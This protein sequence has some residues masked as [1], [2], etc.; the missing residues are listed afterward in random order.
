MAGPVIMK[1]GSKELKENFLPRIAAGEIEF[2]LGY[3]EPD[4]G[5]DLSRIEM[6]AVEDGDD[7]V[8]TG[9]KLFNTCCHFA[10]YHWLA[11]KTERDRSAQKGLSLM[12]VDLKSPGITIS[13]MWEMSDTRTNVVFYDS[14]RVPKRFLVGEVN[15]GWDYMV[16]ALNFERMFVTGGLRRV[17][18]DLI[19]YVK[20]KKSADSSDKDLSIRHE[21]AEME[22][23]IS[24]AHSFAVRV[25]CLQDKGVAPSYE[26]AALKLFVS[27]LYQRIANLGLEILKPYGCLRRDSKYAVLNGRMERLYRSSFLLTIGAG[28]S[29]IMR[30]TI[31]TKGLRLPR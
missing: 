10:Q 29:E 16:S 30:N 1:H 11:V 17:L 31:A 14:V 26:S 4:A 15:R 18:E 24:I 12:I 19:A 5:S 21:L 3:T 8:V 7:F 25:A 27:E 13:P 20:S 2:A 6:W 28:T 9:Q 23:E 22:A